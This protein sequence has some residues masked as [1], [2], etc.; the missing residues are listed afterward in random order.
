[1]CKEQNNYAR[2]K[3]FGAL[4]RALSPA[5]G[6]WSRARWIFRPRVFGIPRA[7]ILAHL[8]IRIL[9]KTGKIIGHLNRTIIRPEQFKHDRHA[10][11]CDHWRCG[12]A[13]HL[14]EPHR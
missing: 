1:I 6:L 10:P 9:P 5:L 14:L 11:G 7:K 3:S 13:E 12:E 2:R 4:A 8:W